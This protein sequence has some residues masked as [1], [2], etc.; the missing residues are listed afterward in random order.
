[1]TFPHPTLQGGE[2]GFRCADGTY[3]KQAYDM[4]HGGVFN[5][6]NRYNNLLGDEDLAANYANKQGSVVDC[7]KYPITSKLRA[8][9]TTLLCDHVANLYGETNHYYVASE[10]GIGWRE[11]NGI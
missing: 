7:S 2:R 10:C 11:P 5:K 9:F 8:V 6:K 4:K 1:M 3:D